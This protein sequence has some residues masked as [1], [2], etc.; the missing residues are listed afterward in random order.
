MVIM[1]EPVERSAFGNCR[2]DGDVSSI[3]IFCPLPDRFQ[4]ME[5]TV[6]SCGIVYCCWMKQQRTSYK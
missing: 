1:G 5:Q 4:E 2:D 6:T 3:H